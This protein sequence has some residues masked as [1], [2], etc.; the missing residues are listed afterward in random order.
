M[1]MYIR[2]CLNHDFLSRGDQRTLCKRFV[3]A[4]IWSQVLFHQNVQ[5]LAMVGKIEETF[6]T[7]QP[8]SAR[9]VKFM[10]LMVMK[11]EKPLEWAMRIDEEAELAD[12]ET[13]KPQEIKLMK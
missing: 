13:L 4:S 11:G 8:I 1:K 12:L 3:E 5:L 10:D 9:K 2:T 7:L 6:F